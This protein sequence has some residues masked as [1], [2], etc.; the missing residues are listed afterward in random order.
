MEVPNLLVGNIRKFFHRFRGGEGMKKAEIASQRLHQQGL[1]QA[2]FERP[3]HV[4]G[5]LG[6]VQAQDYAAA[7]WA[8]AQRVPG[9]TNAA[10]DQA[11][12]SGDILRTH[13][14]RPTWHF[15]TPSDIRWMLELTAPRVNVASAYYYH[16]LELDETVFA[17]SEAVLEKALQ[18]GGQLT[19]SELGETLQG[20]GIDTQDR[21]RLTYIVM[22]AE[23]DAVICS[24]PRRGKQFTY[25]LLEER[26]PQARILDH[27]EGL[28]ELTQRYFTGHGPAT[29]RDFAWWSGLTVADASL[30]VEMA[31][32]H[33]IREAIDGQTYWLAEHKTDI[34]APSPTVHLLP[35]YDEYIIG[36]QDRSAAFDAGD[37]KMKNPRDNV[38]FNHTILINGKVSGT[39][40]RNISKGK[41]MLAVD[42]FVTL[43]VAEEKGLDAAVQRYGEF[44]GMPVEI[45]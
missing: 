22:R 8:L 45:L 32:T 7:K 37:T 4:V 11:F 17:R 19:R 15:V 26:V 23:L 10:I 31:A 42:P 20:A 30:G 13:V 33:L 38:V 24:G 14:M 43:S 2:R 25:A 41:V 5:W 3:E 28:A 36:Y 27:D 34:A 9:L 16:R 35:N 21:M 40:K 44:H 29:I 6:A 12:A 1:L 39:W 18:D